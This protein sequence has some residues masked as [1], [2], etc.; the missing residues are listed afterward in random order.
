MY[1]GLLE[2]TEKEVPS[3]TVRLSAE[4]AKALVV[5]LLFHHFEVAQILVV[6]LFH[7]LGQTPGGPA[8]RQL[9]WGP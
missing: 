3:L 4:S 5:L 9:G 7:V 1:L 8:W 2:S 6:Q